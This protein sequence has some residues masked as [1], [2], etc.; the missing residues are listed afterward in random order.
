[1]PMQSI[2]P[3]IGKSCGQVKNVK[4]DHFAVITV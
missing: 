1:M 4:T 3:I 2:K